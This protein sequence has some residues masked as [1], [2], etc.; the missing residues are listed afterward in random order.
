M[1]EKSNIN[2]VIEALVGKTGENISVSLFIF[3]GTSFSCE[4]LQT[5]K[6]FISFMTSFFVIWL[7]G[8][9]EPLF[10]FFFYC[11]NTGIVAIF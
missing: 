10:S 4:V 8:K 1:L 5:S 3:V 11:Q 6:Y 2:H 7:K 9:I